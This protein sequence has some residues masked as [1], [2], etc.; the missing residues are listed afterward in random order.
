MVFY[1]RE[2]FVKL[3]FY[4]VSFLVYLYKYAARSLC[5]SLF[6]ILL[7]LLFV[8]SMMVALVMALT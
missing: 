4:V 3:G 5:L 7:S 2:G 1:T 8:H 6:N